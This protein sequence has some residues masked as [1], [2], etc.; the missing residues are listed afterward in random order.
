MTFQIPDNIVRQ[1][2]LTEKELLL[3]LGIVFFQKGI[4]SLKLAIELSKV[5]EK[6]FRKILSKRG[7]PLRNKNAK[8][9]DLPDRYLIAQQFKGRARH[10]D[11]PISKYDVYDQ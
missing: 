4:L 11:F 6:N 8:E 10:P 3:E 5:S 9:D 1:L 2:K 7:V